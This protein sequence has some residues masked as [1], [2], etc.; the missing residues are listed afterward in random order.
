M[1]LLQHDRMVPSAMGW[2]AGLLMYHLDERQ[3]ELRLRARSPSKILIVDDV[4]SNLR[5]LSSA[6]IQAG[7][8]VRNAISGKVAMMGIAALVQHEALGNLDAILPGF[9]Y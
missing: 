1:G 9:Q 7:Y 6:L 8:D 3:I 2:W 5:L 4:P